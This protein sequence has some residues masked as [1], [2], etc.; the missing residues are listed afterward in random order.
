[1]SKIKI[2]TIIML[3]LPLIGC[4]GVLDEKL[5]KYSP[6]NPQNGGQFIM[7]SNISPSDTKTH[8][9]AKY[10]SDKCTRTHY[11]SSFR[12]TGKDRRTREIKWDLSDQNGQRF[13]TK[14]PLGG[15][16]WC[17]WELSEINIG[18]AYTQHPLATKDTNFYVSAI[19]TVF[20][21]DV[22]INPNYKEIYEYNN[23]SYSPVFHIVYNNSIN[24]P[25]IIFSSTQN[26]YKYRLWVKKGNNGYINYNPKVDKLKI[27][28]KTYEKGEYIIEHQ[29]I[30]IK[31][32]TN[33]DSNK[34]DKMIIPEK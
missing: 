15:G 7:V 19:L 30:E 5:D 25:S 1:M 11:N 6:I 22:T 20:I 10:I 29:N 9:T 34:I 12:P 28:K 2:L 4:D 14:I 21:N 33:I 16:G 32:R 23:I 26:K 24:F 27:I 31:N 17:Q 3:S 13:E 8:I 18:L